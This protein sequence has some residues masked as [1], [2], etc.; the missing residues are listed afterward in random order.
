MAPELMQGHF[1]KSA[2]IFRYGDHVVVSDIVLWYAVW[3]SAY[4]NWH[5]K[6]SYPVVDMHG[7]NFVLATFLTN[8]PLVSG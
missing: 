8:L 7:I 6:W 4:W 3:G 1:G 5:V 2:D